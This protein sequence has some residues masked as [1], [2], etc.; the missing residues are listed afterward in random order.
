MN[1]TMKVIGKLSLWSL[2]LMVLV[3]V[4]K[5]L[6]AYLMALLLPI[7]HKLLAV[8]LLILGV[9][10]FVGAIATVVAVYLAIRA[11]QRRREEKHD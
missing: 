8:L 1:R 11:W 5:Q 4:G 2:L 10:V 9:L 3:W 7:L 6:L